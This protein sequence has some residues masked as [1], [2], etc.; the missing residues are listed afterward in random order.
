M[1]KALK[2]TK[3]IT[4]IGPTTNSLEA[5]ETLYRNGMNTIRLNFS[6][7]DHE[8][9]GNR[10]VWAKEITKK[11]KKPISILLD[12]KGPEIRIGK[13]QGG[14][15]T[16][17]AGRDITIYTKEEDYKNVACGE[18]ELTM[19]HDIS[20]DVKKGDTILVDDGKL[21]LNT[22]EVKDGI[23]EAKAFNTHVL[24]TNKR[25]NLPG[26]DIT[27]PFLSSKD[28]EDIIFGIKQGIDYI[29]ASFVSYVKNVEDIR[30]ILKEN[31]A[32]HIQIISKIE[33]KI[34]IDNIDSIIDA[35]DGIMVA[36]GDLGLEI[37]YWE[38]PYWEKKIIRKC[39]N[40]SKPC[41][42]A[43][44]MLESMI[45]NPHPT[46]A[47]VTDVY[48]ATELGADATMLSG[49]SANGLYPNITV[50]TMSIINK[51][52]EQDFHSKIYYKKQLELACKTSEGTRADIAYKLAKKCE[53]GEYNYAFVLSNTGELLKTISKYRPNVSIIG[54]TENNILYTTFGI[55]HS[56][57][58]NKVE[59]TEVYK[60]DMNEVEKILKKW[61][62]QTGEVCLFIHSD[63]ITEIKIK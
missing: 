43:T 13:M 44:Q 41:I 56:I 57:F 51:R 32:E 20:K 49:E 11:I 34:G 19:S 38:L 55:W 62:A 61:G 28:K 26:I 21:Q 58:M 12:T 40:K 63:N 3:I 37:P 48:F 50:K 27:M 25:V 14:Q 45:D 10:I 2:N 47:E 31:N 15:Q 59:D 23:V 52:A 53:N 1:S 4:T 5:I 24:K 6:H 18:N 54:V 33:S 9:Q 30:A 60:K 46:R 36:R 22:I 8:E 35:S 17:E 7:G 42:V 16:I 29:A 39:R